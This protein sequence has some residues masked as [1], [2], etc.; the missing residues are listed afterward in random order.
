[1]GKI[2]L[3]HEFEQAVNNDEIFNYCSFLQETRYLWDVH[4]SL[5]FLNFKLEVA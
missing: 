4:Y 3:L 2:G 5:R 1:M